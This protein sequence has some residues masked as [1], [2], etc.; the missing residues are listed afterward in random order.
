MIR[1]SL[2]LLKDD[3]LKDLFDIDKNSGYKKEMKNR[4]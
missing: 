4:N 1:S 3:D 2:M